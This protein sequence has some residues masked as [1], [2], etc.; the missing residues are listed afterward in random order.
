MEYFF[1]WPCRSS[2][3]VISRVSILPVSGCRGTH[4]H[5]IVDRALPV[6]EPRLAPNVQALIADHS[7][8]GAGISIKMCVLC[9]GILDLSQPPEDP[10]DYWAELVSAAKDIQGQFQRALAHAT[11]LTMPIQEVVNSLECN[12]QGK[13]TD[14]MKNMIFQHFIPGEGPCLTGHDPLG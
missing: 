14:R 12:E 1:L 4:T 3:L 10:D 13:P 11:D 5:H 9:T 2:C 8:H 6:A 7:R